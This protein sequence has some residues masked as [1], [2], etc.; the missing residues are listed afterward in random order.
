MHLSLQDLQVEIDEKDAS[1]HRLQFTLNILEL[2]QDLEGETKISGQEEDSPVTTPMSLVAVNRDPFSLK[3]RTDVAQLPKAPE[4]PETVSPREP[5]TPKL[6]LMGIMDVAG[7][8]VAIINDKVLR[9]GE[10]VHRQRIDAIK[11]DHVIMA[12][13]D[14]TYRLYLKGVSPRSSEVKK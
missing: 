13:G 4:T 7:S 2:K 9:P 6:V 11:D 12:E 5:T 3:K 1:M 10:I 14:R 8:R